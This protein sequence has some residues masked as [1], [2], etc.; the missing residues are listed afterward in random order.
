MF[1]TSAQQPITGPVG[2]P[3][4]GTAD[5]GQYLTNAYGCHDCHGPDL[6]G[7]TSTDGPSGPNLTQIV[8]GWT[9]E[10]FVRFFR[11]GKDPTGRDVPP[12]AMPWRSY[13]KAFT[14]A[15]LRDLYSYLHGLEQVGTAK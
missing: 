2:A 13:S 12:D 1:P 9:E 3:A 4:A 6:A 7:M 5:Y 15:Q 10:Q 14:D 11:E 8:P